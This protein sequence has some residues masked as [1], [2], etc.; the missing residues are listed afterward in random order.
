MRNVTQ[1]AIKV[2]A[3]AMVAG[4]LFAMMWT[5]TPVPTTPPADDPPVTEAPTTHTVESR[6]SQFGEKAR[7]RLAPDFAAAGVA[8]PPRD[9][10]LVGLKRE[11]RLELFARGH[12]DA[13]PRFIKS[14]AFAAWTG[15]LGPKLREGDRQIPEGVYGISY[16]NPNSIAHVSLRIGY[17]NRMERARGAADGR[18]DL[19]GD[20]MIHGFTWGSQGCV[21]LENGEVE[22]VFTLAADIGT[23]NVQV[24]LSPM[25]ARRGPLWADPSDPA[26]TPELYR[27]ITA[28]LVGLPLGAAPSERQLAVD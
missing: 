3:M 27:E 23:E 22:E 6:L 10:V 5:T 9:I 1:I 21:V 11:R 15:S 14:Y 16:L 25:D 28:A 19:G 20:I 4:P 13:V 17:P 7:E 8:Y 26:W 12:T 24:V 18:A 2:L